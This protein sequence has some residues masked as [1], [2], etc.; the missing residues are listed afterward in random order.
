LLNEEKVSTPTPITRLRDGA[1]TT[2][3]FFFNSS[4]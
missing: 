4:S 3:S 1:A 2:G